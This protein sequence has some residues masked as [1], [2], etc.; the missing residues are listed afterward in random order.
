MQSDA[1]PATQGQ[2]HI[3]SLNMNNTS[4][5]FPKLLVCLHTAYTIK[6]EQ[7]LGVVIVYLTK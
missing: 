2:G 1:K 4:C 3:V 5:N 7:I 6:K